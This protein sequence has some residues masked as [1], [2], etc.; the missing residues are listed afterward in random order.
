MRHYFVAAAAAVSLLGSAVAAQAFSPAP[1]SQTSGVIL[2]SGGCGPFAHRGFNGECYPNHGRDFDRPRFRDGE[3][4]F[5]RHRD[6][7]RRERFGRDD[8]DHRHDGDRF[9]GR[10]R[11]DD[12]QD[13]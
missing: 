8:G 5:D 1:V 3:G 2:I 4:R 12:R 6:F 7:D 9:D 10:R 11:H 13:D